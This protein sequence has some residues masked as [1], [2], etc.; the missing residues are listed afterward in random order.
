M[1][2]SLTISGISVDI[3][4]P[5]RR[6][7]STI[8]FLGNVFFGPA[9]G[10]IAGAFLTGSSLGWRWTAWITIIISGPSVAVACLI[11][12]ETY[13]PELQRRRKRRSRDDDTQPANS[14]SMGNRTK[15]DDFVRKYLKI[16][17]HML[18]VE[19]LLAILTV[20]LSLVYGILYLTLEA[21]PISFQIERGWSIGIAS[22]PF[23]GLLLGFVIA[24]VVL[25]FWPCLAKI[26]RL[27]KYGPEDQLVPM[28]FG[29]CLLPV[30]LFWFSGT[31]SPSIHPAPQ[32][33][34]TVPIGTGILLVFI[35]G[36]GYIIETYLVLA[37]AG[38]SANSFVR[39]LLGFAFP[40]FAP[41]MYRNLGTP[42]ATRTLA[43]CTV[44]L[45]PF[46]FVFRFYGR[47]VRQ[48]SRYAFKYPS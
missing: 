15:F 27:D 44:L 20:Y 19:P 35:P 23:A 5:E 21:F 7:L 22:L 2:T 1:I 37:N 28:M 34:S 4:D 47:K 40:L 24:S 10:P 26:L 3:L 11:I 16:P 31:S 42:W 6:R 38:L 18:L 17:L 13:Q 33:I 12:P 8:L 48:Q 14:S 46:P 30:G 9:V 32:I 43:F 25:I 29:A 36:L 39:S 41:A 45:A